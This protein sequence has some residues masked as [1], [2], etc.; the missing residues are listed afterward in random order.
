MKEQLKSIQEQFSQD[1]AGAQTPAQ[2][3]E[4]RVKYLGRKSQLTP[5]FS[6]IPTL[7]KK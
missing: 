5:L 3:E 7:D 1:I 6:K 2:L 4:L